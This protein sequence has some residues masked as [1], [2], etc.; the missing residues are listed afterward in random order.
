MNKWIGDVFRKD[1][2]GKAIPLKTKSKG[3]IPK[4]VSSTKQPFY[5]FEK[6]P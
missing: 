4:L 2:G 3:S 1:R 5:L 6:F